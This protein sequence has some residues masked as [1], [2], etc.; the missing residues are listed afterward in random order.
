M[1]AARN[2]REALGFLAVARPHVIVSD[3]AMPGMA[4]LEFIAHVRQLPGQGETRTPAI[5]YT[6]SNHLRA[7]ALAAGFDSYVV[8]GADR[9]LLTDE[10][11][12]LAPRAR[13]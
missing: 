4:G 13:L 1:H 6:T 7:A 9:R 8:K 3:L 2:A 11:V 5:A 12:R 10:V